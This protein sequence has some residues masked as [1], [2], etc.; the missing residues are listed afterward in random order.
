MYVAEYSGNKISKID[1]TA[2][3]PTAVDVVTSLSGPTGLLLHGNDLYITESSANKVSKLDIT[4]TSPAVVDFVTTGFSF[5]YG[6]ALY[7]SVL[8]VPNT[9]GNTISKV[10]IT[11]DTPSAVFEVSVGGSPSGLALNENDLY[12][13]QFSDN[14]ISKYVLPTLSSGE[15]LTLSDLNIYPNPSK[16]FIQI[17]NLN[18]VLNYKVYTLLG[19]E[20]LKGSVSGDEKIN[21]QSLSNQMYILQFNNGSAIRFIKE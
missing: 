11:A 8:Y 5:P 17:S 10:D 6:L 16:N 13:A 14:K 3:T 7:E 1:L 15:Q 2:T 4:D 12:M 20:V 19:A 18:K 9:G 21:I